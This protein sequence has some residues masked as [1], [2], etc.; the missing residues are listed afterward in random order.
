MKKYNNLALFLS[1]SLIVAG[2]L[3]VGSS[4]VSAAECAVQDIQVVSFQAS[5]TA[6]VKNIGSSRCDL[7]FVSYQIYPY[8]N[9]QE[10]LRNQVLFNQTHVSLARNEQRTLLVDMPACRYQ[11]DLVN[12]VKEPPVYNDAEFVDARFSGS[13]LPLCGEDPTPTPTRTPTPTPTFTPT[14]TPTITP[15]PTPTITPTP[16]PYLSCSPNFQTV[17]SGQYVNFVATGAGGPSTYSWHASNGSPA[18]A[19]GTSN[20][21]TRFFADYIDQTHFVTVTSGN[22]SQNCIVR[23]LANTYTP[24]PTPS[25]TFTI[26]KSVRNVTTGSGEVDT[27][28]ANPNDTLEFMIRVNTGVSTV[29]NIRISDSLPSQLSYISGSTT[30]N[31]SYYGDGV[32]SGGINTGTYSSYQ[33]ITLRFRANV[34]GTGSFNTGTTNLTNYGYASADNLGTISDTAVVSVNKTQADTNL[35]LSITKYGRNITLGQAAEQSSVRVLNGNT[36]EF[37]IRV[38]SLSNLN[39]HNVIVTDLLPAGIE[40]LPRTTSVNNIIVGDTIMSG[41]NVGSL[42]PGQE[43]MIRFSGRVNALL[44]FPSGSL[45]AHN[46]AQARADNVPTVSAQLP[47]TLGTVAGVSTGPTESVFLALGLSALVTALYAAYTRT[48][49]FQT[50]LAS[51]TVRRHQADGLNFHR[52]V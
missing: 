32:V 36:V 11:L 28:S 38:R 8:A 40:Y 48:G 50:R 26:S 27:V 39:L 44:S 7:Y 51:A 31:G 18:S 46:T 30:V 37:I 12:R 29:S 33:T 3:F 43:S 16:T 35:A 34:N 22:Q 15:T 24:T 14:P 2:V 42:A 19:A 10:F 20:F 52:F 17:L 6:T 1:L 9:Q 5:G 41:L 23:V 45:V 4:P 13:N 21:S 25:P 47:L 49:L